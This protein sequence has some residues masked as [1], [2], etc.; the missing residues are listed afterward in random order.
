MKAVKRLIA[1]VM[2]AM[3]CLSVTAC[4]DTSY[5]AVAEGEKLP[6]GLYILCQLSALGEVSSQED[7][8]ATLEDPWDNVIDGM[9][10]EDWV[11]QRAQELLKTYV[12]VE[13][14]FEEKGLELSEDDLK[15][16]DNLVESN[17]P[18]YQETY[19]EY[20]ISEDSYRL[21]IT[22]SKKY[23]ELFLHYY[24][25]GGEEEI[26]DDQLMAHY[27]E[28]YAQFKM[29]SFSKYDSETGETMD[30][31]GLADVKAEADRYLELA[32]EDGADFDA[33]IEQYEK[34]TS[35]SDSTDEETDTEETN[36]MIMI[37]KDEAS[38][39]VS[40]KLSSAIFEEA[41]I[42]EPILL[43]DDYGYYVVLRYD[44]AD[45]ETSYEQM[46][47]TVLYDLKKDDFDAVLLERAESLDF[48]MNQ[49]AVKRYKAT[50]LQ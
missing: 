29:I 30:D 8:D 12:E 20:G 41:K 21:Q 7:Y 39:Y 19:E 33:L 18:N 28:E 35:T 40:S 11:N 34:E 37:Q 26:T 3:F 45:D 44:V 46:R 23:T 2:A 1:A 27:Q 6:A 48:E 16:V 36:N 5:S 43:S 32:K 14:E 47:E 17:W 49:D 24:G 25:E 50:K 4:G 38:Y 22:N 13:K 31:E 42:G 10:V 9:K 15:E